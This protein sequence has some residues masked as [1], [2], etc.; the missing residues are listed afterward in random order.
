MV[1]FLGGVLICK[2]DGHGGESWL[3]G[4]W[5]GSALQPAGSRRSMLEGIVY[6]ALSLSN[7]ATSLSGTDQ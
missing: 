6:W 3:H 2:L 1:P 5:I 4:F 7:L